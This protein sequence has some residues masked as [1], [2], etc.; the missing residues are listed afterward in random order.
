MRG[1][2]IVIQCLREQG[3]EVVFGYPGGAILPLYDALYGAREVLRHVLPTH[4]QHGAH[5]ADGYAR[6]S[7]KIGVCLATSGPGATNLV[8]GIAASFMDSI[9]VVYITANIPRAKRGSDSFQEA[10]IW[11]ITMS[12]TKHSVVVASARSLARELREAFFIAREGRPGP[13]LVDIPKDVLEEADDTYTFLDQDALE[14]WYREN[15]FLRQKGELFFQRQNRFLDEGALDSIAHTLST[16]KRPVILAGGGVIRGK[17]C[18]ALR[19]V[20]HRLDAPVASTLMGI[21]AIPYFDRHFLGM[22]GMHGTRGANAAL[23]KCDVLLAVGTRF[24]DRTLMNAQRFAPHAHVI[25]IDIDRAEIN[26]TVSSYLHVTAD[27]RAI[28]EPLAQRLP[29]IHRPVWWQTPAMDQQGE[30]WTP[31][32]IMTAMARIAQYEGIVVTDVGQHQMWVAQAYPFIHPGQ[33]ITSGGSGTMG[34]GL[35]GAIGAQLAQ[36][37]ALVTLVTGDGS[38]LMNQAELTTV[39]RERLPIIIVV[40]D[41]RALGMVRQWQSLF[42]DGRHMATGLSGIPDYEK[43]AAAYGMEGSYVSNMEA[44]CRAYQQAVEERRSALILC[45]IDPDEMVRPMVRP[46][47]SLE[48]YIL[49]SREES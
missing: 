3:V 19:E 2:E 12:I 33:M 39:A 23:Q 45:R 34:Y 44:F 37:D 36:P 29:F 4:E 48:S 9:P 11:G 6:A 31:S 5:A 13:V 32:H 17:A 43:L 8:T 27:A 47:G 38:F 21:T 41:N 35:G 40:M 26:K 7:G 25:H 46:Q 18:D 28:L 49:E 24:S 15:R 14:A 30:A 20:M 22:A 10:D 16:A 1:A 42:Y